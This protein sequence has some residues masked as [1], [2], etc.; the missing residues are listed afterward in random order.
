MLEIIKKLMEYGMDFEYE[1]KGSHGEQLMSHE[2]GLDI[3]N[4]N[5]NIYFTLSAPV[6]IVPETENN[7]KVFA[8]QVEDECISQTASF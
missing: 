8:Q 6:E 3:S 4:Q 2:I 5:G 7:Y 1:S